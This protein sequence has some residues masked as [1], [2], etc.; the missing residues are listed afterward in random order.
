MNRWV[1]KD[2][3]RSIIP[4]DNCQLE[5]RQINLIIVVNSLEKGGRTRRILDEYAGILDRGHN[6][7]LVSFSEPPEWV[8]DSNPG[9]AQWIVIP[10][11]QTRFDPV[12]L[13]RLMALF[14]SRQAEVIHAHCETS[15]FYGGLAG[16]LLG[17]PTAGTFH[18]SALRYYRSNWKS[19][20]FYRFLDSFIAVSR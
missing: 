5:G 8:R 20:L 17:I 6:P 4:H 7:V 19:R 12:L 14:R 13:V 16:R 3:S 10:K 11:S 9:S 18:R 2:L 15:S 1:E